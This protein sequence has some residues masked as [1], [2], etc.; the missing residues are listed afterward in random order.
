MFKEEFSLIAWLFRSAKVAFFICMVFPGLFFLVAAGFVTG[1]AW[2][3][4]TIFGAILVV[5]IIIE[6]VVMKFLSK[7][8][9]I[10]HQ[11]RLEEQNKVRYVIIK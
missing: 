1:T 9:E 8:W 5:L 7:K 10:E 4:L 3:V 2:K 11:K 6:W